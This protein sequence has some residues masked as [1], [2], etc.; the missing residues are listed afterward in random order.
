MAKRRHSA[1]RPAITG[2][3]AAVLLSGCSSGGN[4][5]Y[6]DYAKV[7][8]QA[9]SSIFHRSDVPREAPAAIPYASLG[10]RVNGGD[11]AMLVLATDTDGNQLWT[12]SNHVVFQTSGGRITRTVGLPQDLGGTSPHSAKAL[13]PPAAALQ[14]PFS[15]DRLVDY[16]ALGAYGVSI[17]CN[18]LAR[19]LERIKILNQTITTMRVDE[20]CEDRASNWRFVDN[21]W[22]DPKTGFTWRSLQHVAQGEF[23]ET[24]I[25]RPPG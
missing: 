18:A 20:I 8:G 4:S 15:S 10:Y 19:R 3:A 22:L 24:E 7:L 12:S 17:S 9:V 14:Q 5:P 23:V 2:L 6:Q 13:T 25:F 21:Y 11:E 1:K 16:P